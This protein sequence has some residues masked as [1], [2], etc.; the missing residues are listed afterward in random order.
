MAGVLDGIFGLFSLTCS[1]NIYTSFEESYV[2]ESLTVFNNVS[3]RGRI[4]ILLRL[5]HRKYSSAA[6]SSKKSWEPE[7]LVTL[8][9]GLHLL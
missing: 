4:G 7:K 9:Q 2:K 5:A 6:S 1:L 8:Y 3:E